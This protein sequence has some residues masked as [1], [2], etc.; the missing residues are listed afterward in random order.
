MC[1]TLRACVD[2]LACVFV[3][4]SMCER[5]R[6][7]VCVC[8]F[9]LFVFVLWCAC[10]FESLRVYIFGL[11]SSCVYVFMFCVRF[12]SRL[13]VLVMTRETVLFTLI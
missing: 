1:V 3:C 7:C 2:V 10:M 11:F 6:A 4:L 5:V 9:V 8:L 12:C 13:R